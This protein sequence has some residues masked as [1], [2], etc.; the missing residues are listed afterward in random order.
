M[1]ST[2]PD[3]LPSVE[4]QALHF[5][6]VSQYRKSED[7]HN[8]HRF[9]EQITRLDVALRITKKAVQHAKSYQLTYTT[10]RNFIATLED[11]LTRSKN[12]ND[13]I[14]NQNPPSESRLP[15][16]QEFPMVKPIVTDVLGDSQ[17][18][19]KGQRVILSELLPWGA[20]VAFG[21]FLGRIIHECY[22]IGQIFTMTARKTGSG[23]K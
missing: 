21:M 16:I 19:L 14:Y 18:V 17:K 4:L 13:Y 2:W 7:D 8:N 9:G 3:F 10:G 5:S 11:N 15:D 12:D 23:R 20:C 22:N 6:A 1:P